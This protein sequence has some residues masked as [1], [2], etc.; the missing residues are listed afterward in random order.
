MKIFKVNATP[1]RVD[2][3]EQENSNRVGGYSNYILK[4]L[5]LFG[6]DGATVTR[7]QG[8]WQGETEV[9][10]SIEIAMDD[11]GGVP[12]NLLDFCKR[13]C[14]DYNQDAV[15]LTLPNNSVEFIS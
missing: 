11:N 8:M 4:T 15:M 6:I 7:V 12:G 3:S 5:G 1:V 10:F 2:V 9:S 13:I 14:R